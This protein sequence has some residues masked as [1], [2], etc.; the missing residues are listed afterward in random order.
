MSGRAKVK[1]IKSD[2]KDVSELFSQM[3][4]AGGAVN[5]NICYPKYI[6]L[7]GLVDK[8]IKTFD[9]LSDNPFFKKWPE[10]APFA[11]EIKNFVQVAR[12]RAA[13]LFIIDFGEP[14]VEAPANLN[15]LDDEQKKNFSEIFEQMKNDKVIMPT[16]MA[17]CNNLVIYRRSIS[18]ATALD[19][20]FISSMP[21]VEFTPFPFTN[22]NL[23]QLVSN[24]ITES[25][26]ESLK[27]PVTSGTNQM[28]YMMLLLLN[29]IFTLSYNL[30]KTYSQPD[31]DVDEFVNVV[32]SNLKQV[33]GQIPRCDKAFRKIEE[34][35]KL[36]K[37]N[38]GSYYKD[39]MTT[40][41]S[42]II[43]ENFV[44]D[45][46]K[47][48]NADMETTR[49]FREIIKYYK[50]IAQS[51]IKNPQLKMLFEKVNENFKELDKHQNI[52]KSDAEEK[53]RES[54]SESSDESDD[55]DYVEDPKVTEAKRLLLGK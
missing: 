49:Q 7:R 2:N 36:L 24:I 17:V 41:S 10:F 19:Y 1:V 31:I 9:L 32:I 46:A 11:V 35:V 4:G 54:D 21:G 29:K 12:T 40:G 44:L 16:F 14:G 22:L 28:M 55:I 50:K 25:S 5:V 38:F 3:L 51:H 13:E 37:D 23:K 34:S 39:F 53:E 6:A 47:S 30:Y 8:I 45:V 42:T 43:M 20:H 27:V 15:L 26:E 52:A 33:K 48:T 18:D